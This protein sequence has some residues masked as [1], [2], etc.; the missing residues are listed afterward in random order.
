M[1]RKYLLSAILSVTL[2][3]L[4]GCNITGHSDYTVDYAS[5]NG[6]I[7]TYNEK[8]YTP[9]AIQGD[10]D[11]HCASVWSGYE[12]VKFTSYTYSEID[13]LRTDEFFCAPSQ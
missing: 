2:I 5:E 6:I 10:A 12:A 9:N 1:K 7:I 11:I 13:G 3:G 8:A 4:T